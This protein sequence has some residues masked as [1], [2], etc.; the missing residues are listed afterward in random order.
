MPSFIPDQ[1][2]SRRGWPTRRTVQSQIRKAEGRVGSRSQKVGF[3]ARANEKLE[4][5]GKGGGV[6]SSVRWSTNCFPVIVT[7]S[8]RG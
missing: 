1:P 2:C 4:R 3:D 6:G 8:R 5:G 7:P